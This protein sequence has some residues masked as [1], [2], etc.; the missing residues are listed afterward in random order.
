MKDVTL[1]APT[2][3]ES[4]RLR[5]RA[6]QAIPAGAH[7][8]SKGDDQFPQLAPGFITRGKGCHVWDPDGNEYIDWGM[9]LRSVLL[10]H[11]YEPVLS[12]VRQQLETGSNFTRPSPI[13]V[14]FAELLID[15]IPCAEMVKLA[16]NGSDV[17]T[18]AVKLARAYTG[19]DLIVRCQ[20]HPFFSVDDWF[21][22]DT[23]CPSGVPQATRAL[24]LRFAFNDLD[25]LAKLFDAHSNQIA[26]VIT[27]AATRV[28]PASGFL[29]GAK[30]LCHR[31][32]ALFILDEMITGFR[33]HRQGAQAYYSVVPDLAAFGKAMGN[34]F[35]CSALAGRRDV[36][37]LGALGNGRPRTFLLSTTHGGE[38]HAIAA[39]R[40]TVRIV[41][42][43]QVVEHLWRI[44]ASL[45]D[46]FNAI[47][48][49]AGIDRFVRMTGPACSPSHVFAGPNGEPSLPLQ[50]LY[51]QETIRRGVLIPYVAPSYSHQESD[52]ARTLEAI[53]AALGVVADAI[54]AGSV[55]RFLTGPSIKPVFRPAN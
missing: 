7:T 54:D 14:E 27:E 2:F 34:G 43:E 38:T 25:G 20:E 44:G 35:S 23:V 6:R 11:A 24:T 47:A 31:H 8:Y 32:G 55:E 19:R 22:G 51:L 4:D 45:I 36:M 16:K 52:V 9:G 46:G 41:Q 29:Q 33:W 50:T 13:E 26:G 21:I 42:R 1:G 17:T 15:T 28:E 48:R 18:A 3:I 5:Q 49:R 40:E 30:D 39:A 53:D 12:A 37:E 10:G